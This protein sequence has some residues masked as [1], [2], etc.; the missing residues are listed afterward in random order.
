MD[1]IILFTEAVSVF[2]LSLYIRAQLKKQKNKR[3]L[4]ITEELIIVINMKETKTKKFNTVHF[5]TNKKIMNIKN[6]DRPNHPIQ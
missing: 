3:K 1:Y 2:K 4:V 5:L 6:N